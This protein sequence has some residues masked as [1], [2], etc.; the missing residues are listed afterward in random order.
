M[1]KLLENAHRRLESINWSE[2]VVYDETSPTCLK[3]RHKRKARGGKLVERKNN[4]IAGCKSTEAGYV[5]GYQRQ[6]YS[7]AKIVWVMHNRYIPEGYYIECI[8]GDL[9]N[10]KISNLIIKE[11]YPSLSEKYC[12]DLLHYLDYDESSPSC[13]RWKNKFGLGSNV[14]S[15]SPA[16]SIDGI[17]G[18][19]KIHGLGSHYKV[20]RIVWY[21]HN[22]KIPDGFHI[23]HVNRIRADNRISN[24]RL[25]KSEFNSRNRAINKNNTTG[26]GQITYY[27]GLNSRGTLIRKYTVSVLFN[28]KKKTK[29]FSC[30]KYGDVLAFQKA[31]ECRDKFLKE[32]NE[33]GA[34]YSI[35]HGTK[36]P[37]TENSSTEIEDCATLEH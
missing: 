11:Q 32:V 24:L 25:V 14:K 8:D 5:V 6:N 15:G 22:G 21:I 10:T 29:S 20:H 4:G 18:Y 33:A 13:L 9:L 28:Y 37:C 34:G 23:D 19:Y 2:I 26:I 35:G 31:I 30:I 12:E 16:G 1:N 7:V 17:D 27:E 36:V 3:W